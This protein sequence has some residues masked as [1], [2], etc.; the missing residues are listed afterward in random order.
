MEMT[1][2]AI[3]VGIVGLFVISG[4]VGIFFI[5]PGE[6]EAPGPTYVNGVI[7]SDTLW[8]EGNSPYIVTGNILVEPGINLTIEPGVDIRFNGFYYMRIEGRLIAEGAEDNMITFTS[9]KSSPGP[10]D[11]DSIKFTNYPDEGSIFNY[12]NFE[13]G[14]I[15]IDIDADNIAAPNI[16]YCNVKQ[17]SQIG[18]KYYATATP[19]YSFYPYSEISNNTITDN[20]DWGIEVDYYVNIPNASVLIHDNLIEHNIKGISVE[21]NAGSL[22]LN[23]NVIINNVGDG[24]N[25]YYNDELVFPSKTINISIRNNLISYN[26]GNGLI[27]SGSYWFGYT[28]TTI[29]IEHNSIIF[30]EWGINF[31]QH[32]EITDIIIRYNNIYNNTYYDAKNNQEYDKDIPYNWWGTTDSKIIDQHIFDYYDD[33]NKGILNYT[34][35]LMEPD[36]NAPVYLN[37][38]PDTPSIPIGYTSCYVNNSYSYATSTEDPDG[39]QI[40]YGWDWDGDGTVDE[41]SNLVDSG[42]EDNR[43]YSW[44]KPGIYNISVKAM[45]EHVAE[46]GWSD[47][48]TVT[49]TGETVDS[50]LEIISITLSKYGP[51]AGEE[52][53]IYVEIQNTDNNDCDAIVKYY[54]DDPDDGGMQIGSDQEIIISSDGSISVTQS[55]I[56]TAGDHTLYVIVEDLSTGEE[57]TAYLPITVGENIQPVLVLTTGDI[58]IYRFE[59][60]QERTISVEVTCYRQD[61]SN[62]RLVVLDDQNLTID[63]TITPSITMTDGQTTKFYLRIK[64]PRL[65]EGVDKLERDILIQAVGDNGIFSNAEELDIV[66]SESAISLFDPF[67]VM[68]AVATGS[69]ATLGAAAAASRRDENWKYLLLLTFAVPLYTRIHGKKTLDNFVRGQ[70]YGHI[71]SKPGTHFNDIKKTLKVGNGNLAYHLRKLEKEGF[72]KS[73]RDKRYRRFYPVGVEVLEDDGIKLSQTQESILDYIEQ[74]PKSN[75][76]EIAKELKESQQTISYNLNVLVREGFLTEE[77]FKGTKRYEIIEENT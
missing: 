4:L 60:D 63:N 74:H 50:Y 43:S 45:D 37:E 61:V 77:K 24:V 8:I 33:F 54:D 28:Y 65:P 19:G 31:E 58:N 25:C 6:V 57:V 7:S 30:N 29:V 15:A 59:P 10:G 40:K 16:T 23:N 66:V 47:P 41:W 68:G 26:G 2:K 3:A 51:S 72:I 17:N 75:Q 1:K 53:T 34:P 67:F 48:L 64:A 46:S 42:T 27:I 55:W 13:Y 44:T 39:D 52:V 71:Q 18:I 35:F 73:S 62:V 32:E 5:I 56:A 22:T 11:W 36:P 69:L 49:I 76:K 20:G 70:V 21:V 12:C 14:T 38:P 9:N